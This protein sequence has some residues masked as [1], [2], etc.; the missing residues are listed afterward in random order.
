MIVSIN[1]EEVK[2]WIKRI[3]K[4]ALINIE[5]REEDELTKDV[6]KIIN[7][8]NKLRELNVDNVEPLFMT[9]RERPIIRED[10]VRRGLTEEEALMNVK[11]KIEGYIKGPKTV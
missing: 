4:L 9:P 3:S 7:F 1:I 10:E 11:E 6:I 8:F 5:E 2:K